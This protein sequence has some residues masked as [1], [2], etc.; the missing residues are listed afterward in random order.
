VHFRADKY[1]VGAVAPLTRHCQKLNEC[2]VGPDGKMT[3]FRMALIEGD[4]AGEE[5]RR[6][7][8]AAWRE[9]RLYKT[10]VEGPAL[11]PH[12]ALA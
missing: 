4:D 2:F 8:E 1:H 10:E 7:R 5:A 12:A 6:E 11:L 3:A 9:R